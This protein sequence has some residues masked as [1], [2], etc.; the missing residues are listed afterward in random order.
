VG[1]A[2]VTSDATRMRVQRIMVSKRTGRHS[3]G[4]VFEYRVWGRHRRACRLLA[5]FADER[6]LERIDDCYLLV[7]D[8]S[9]NAKIRANRLK[10][11]R[12]IAERKGFEQWTSDR[13]PG[14]DTMPSPFGA[15]FERFDP[16]RHDSNPERL[17]EIG[18]L[19]AEV[20]VHPVFVT[21]LRRR[22]R[23]GALRAEASNIRIHRTGQILHTLSIE[24]DD[25]VQ[26]CALRRRLGLRGEDNV[27]VHNVL[28]G[29]CTAPSG[30]RG[31]IEMA[32]M[33]LP[34]GPGERI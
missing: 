13:H 18:A 34:R 29:A 21:K 23:V 24:G 11:K 32:D 10:V 25:L 33:Q 16:Q 30:R 7:D 12:L 19:A 15:M 28:I 22:Y 6:T 9:W 20:G 5:E 26:L 17:A 2:A 4:A 31:D 1:A 8:P 14:T 27:A 3:T